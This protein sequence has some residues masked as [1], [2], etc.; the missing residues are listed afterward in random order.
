MAAEF[1]RELVKERRRL[2]GVLED[3]ERQGM[4]MGGGMGHG[5]VDLEGWRLDETQWGGGEWE[6]RGEKEYYRKKKERLRKQAEREGMRGEDEGEEE[7][8]EE[9]GSEGS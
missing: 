4:G 9:S 5:E 2:V 7:G 1:L 8:E 3:A 6:N